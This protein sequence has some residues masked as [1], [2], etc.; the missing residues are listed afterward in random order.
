[1]LDPR[2][3][4]SMAQTSGTISRERVRHGGGEI[5]RTRRRRGRSRAAAP[6]VAAATSAVVV[7]VTRGHGLRVSA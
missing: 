2:R 4:T 3:A 5:D 7:S 6:H 1:V